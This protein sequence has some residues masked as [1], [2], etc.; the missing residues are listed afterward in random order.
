MINYNRDKNTYVRKKKRDNE[1]L[2]LEKFVSKAMP[3]MEKM[4]EENQTIFF[5]ENTA[6]AAKRNAVELNQEIKFP[7]DILLLFA[8][9][10]GQPAELLRITSIHMFESAP[11]YK[12]SIS[13][14]IQKSDGE[15]VYIAIVYNTVTKNQFEISSI[16]QCE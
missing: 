10:D 15:L 4:V 5:M 7:Q 8:T 12:C 9:E 3:V 13:Y 2:N 14:T 6:A 1:A 16:C 11:Q